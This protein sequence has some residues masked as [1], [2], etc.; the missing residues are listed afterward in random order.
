MESIGTLGT[1][2]WL[3]WHSFAAVGS[4]QSQEDDSSTSMLPDMVCIP[5]MV[6]EKKIDKLSCF[7]VN[8]PATAASTVGQ[9]GA[10]LLRHCS[11]ERVCPQLNMHCLKHQAAQ[12]G[13]VVNEGLTKGFGSKDGVANWAKVGVCFS[14]ECRQPAA[15]HAANADETP[16]PWTL[17][18]KRRPPFSHIMELSIV[19]VSIHQ[20]TSAPLGASQQHST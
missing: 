20:A 17:Y 4:P 3:P 6:Q 5:K 12:I 13:E 19:A 1:I 15:R 14:V 18:P 9:P 7:P 16:Q 10:A 2:C 8:Q 11:R